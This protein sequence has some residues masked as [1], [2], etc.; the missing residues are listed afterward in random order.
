M[1]DNVTVGNTTGQ[2]NDYAVSADE[3]ASGNKIQRVKIAYSADGS[4]V[5][6]PVDQE[7][8]LVNSDQLRRLLEN[9]WL[10]LVGISGADKIEQTVQVALADLPGYQVFRL[11]AAATTNAT[12]VTVAPTL[13]HGWFLQNVAASSRYVKLYTGDLGPNVGT[14]KPVM[15]LGLP[16]GAAANIH[17]DRGIGFPTGLGL[18]ITTGQADTDTTA[19]AAGDVV[20][21]LLY[22]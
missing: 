22:D 1:A 7:G 3:D 6:A 11:I 18:A 12:Q 5:H 8:V 20:V 14:D 10:E 4:D 16:A 19:V 15:T 13:V 17:F 21:N 2:P 9:I